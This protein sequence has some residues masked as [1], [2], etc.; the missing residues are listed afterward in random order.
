MAE[1]SKILLVES[2]FNYMS[3]AGFEPA[4]PSL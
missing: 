2:R 3:D 4:T 1:P